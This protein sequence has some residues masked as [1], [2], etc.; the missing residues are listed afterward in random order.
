VR[1]HLY[2]SIVDN[3]GD[4]GVCWRL[5]RQLRAEYGWLVTLWVDDWQPARA[6]LPALP[7]HAR[8]SQIDS[9]I[10]APWSD[11]RDDVDCVGDVF[12]EGFAC[13]PPAS[14]LQQLGA[15]SRKPVWIN[16]E[17]FSAEPWV[18]RH[19]GLSGLI[20]ERG[21][22]RWFFVPGVTDASGGMLRE[23]DLLVRR[24][25]WTSAD[26]RA[27]TRDHGLASAPD[28]PTLVC[29]AYPHAP[30]DELI[31]AMRADPATVWLC[32]RYSQAGCHASLRAAASDFRLIDAP[33]VPQTEF[34]ALLWSA[35]ALLVRGEDSLM[36]AL[37][38]GR[39]FVWQIYPQDADAHVPK[40]EAWLAHYTM[41]W[42]AA[43]A[44]A[45]GAAHASWNRL[46]G[47]P[48]FADAWAALR[49]LWPDWVRWSA[50]TCARMATND[51]LARRFVDFVAARAAASKTP[52]L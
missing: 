19:H 20:A 2:C 29:F 8:P 12:V 39:P 9:V 47:A 36:R 21:A 1:L 35:D 34:D 24:D 4:I 5:A 7:E 37:W 45:L 31:G 43:L 32:G 27:F 3:F 23:R 28:R 38:A 44:G 49:A 51:D 15:R 40:L 41:G 26:A 50:Q 6:L 18:D 17:Y 25:A 33:F 42:P 46:R 16:L 52:G 10:I 48:D 13:T 30:Y 11:A 22:R 14:A